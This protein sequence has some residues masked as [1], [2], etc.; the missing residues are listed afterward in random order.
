MDFREVSTLDKDP[1]EQVKPEFIQRGCAGLGLPTNAVE[2]FV[3]SLV[4]VGIHSFGGCEAVGTESA[5][6]AVV[7]T[8]SAVVVAVRVGV[9]GESSM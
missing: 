8:E 1:T 2:G 6:V 7:G 3:S 4:I 5:V 9:R